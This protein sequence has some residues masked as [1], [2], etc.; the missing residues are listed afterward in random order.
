ML[1]FRDLIGTI[2]AVEMG[3]ICRIFLNKRCNSPTTQNRFNIFGNLCGVAIF[4]LWRNRQ[5]YFLHD[6]FQLLRTRA[7]LSCLNL[8]KYVENSLQLILFLFLNLVL[9]PPGFNFSLLCY[10]NQSSN[11]SHL[12]PAP[13]STTTSQLFLSSS[14]KTFLTLAAPFFF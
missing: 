3:V 9:Y 1:D 13:R 8:P 10:S 14:V 4:L 7:L 6:L 12:Q 11:E 5:L 2:V